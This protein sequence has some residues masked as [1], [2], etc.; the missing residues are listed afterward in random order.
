MH[1]KSVT[2]RDFKRFSQLEIKDLPE[3][4]RLVV[5]AG[6]NG[7][8]KSSL[9]DAFRIW[10]GSYGV[11]I[12]WDHLYHPKAGP[13]HSAVPTAYANQVSLELYEPLP[14]DQA[15][16]RGMFYF[17]TAYRHEADFTSSQVH[18][19]TVDAGP[20]IGRMVEVDQSVQQNYQHLVMTVMDE[21]FDETHEVTNREIRERL[22]SDLSHAMGRLFSGIALTGV[23]RPL[24]AGSFYFDKGTSRNFH[25]K[26]L[27]GGEKAAFDLLLDLYIRA[28]YHPHAIFCIDEPE[29]HHNP[30][31]QGALL[32]EL[33]AVL[34]AEGQLWIATHSIG[35]LRRARDIQLENPD[36]VVFL[37]FSSHDMDQRVTLQPRRVDRAFWKSLVEVALDDLASLLAPEQIVLC[38]GG[39]ADQFDAQCLRTIFALEMPSTDF[40]SIGN[41]F[42][43]QKADGA[44]RMTAT[45][46]A[47]G[48]DVLRVID[49]DHRSTNETAILIADGVRVLSRRHLEAFLWDDDVL[50]ALAQRSGA[51]PNR[52]I[53]VKTE[54][55][56]ESVSRGN[57]PDDMKSAAGSAYANLRQL[58]NLLGAGSTAKAFMR[59][60]LAP[61]ITPGMSVYAEL[62]RDIFG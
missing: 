27:S 18:R 3:R 29:L 16:Q 54:A 35:M 60:T 41:T 34:P 17:R 43:V 4:A 36:Q 12:P 50:T 19:V 48:T 5:L 62:K 2:I 57:D 24:D 42:D 56:R 26:N 13:A 1:V 31:I 38:E 51:D 32:D 10:H 28:R 53:A 45:A 47:S 15:T 30:R 7:S 59:D 55:L 33:L 23:G 25:Y 58:L 49:R 21:V 39:L 11:G 8:G 22:I 44:A 20:R 6:P 14:T 61:L 46:I 9:F 40:V 52:V 37:D